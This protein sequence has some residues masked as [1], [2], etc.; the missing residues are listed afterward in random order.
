MAF[1]V[2]LGHHI[3]AVTVAQVIPLRIVAVVTGAHSIDVEA[4]HDLKVLNHALAAHH[5]AAVGIHF[6]AVGAL[7]EHG[8]TVDE[9]LGILDFH[10][11]EAHFVGHHFYQ[12]AAFLAVQLIH[13][14]NE[15]I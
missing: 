11:A 15:R 13:F 3:D 7:D 8:L 2:G 6:V 14:C 9:Q 1:L 12:L 10:F 4:L 5:V